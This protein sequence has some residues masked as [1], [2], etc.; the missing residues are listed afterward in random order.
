ML[1][2]QSR[3][4]QK[5][6][7][8][9]G[10]VWIF[11]TAFLIGPFSAQAQVSLPGDALGDKWV[12]GP[13][14]VSLGKIAQLRVP[15][16]SWQFG[17]ATV[18]GNYL[19]KAG[20]PVPKG[21][22]GIMHSAA[23][24]TLVFEFEEAGYVKEPPLGQLNADALLKAFREHFR[25]QFPQAASRGSL[26]WELEPQYNA[27]EHFTEWALQI[28]TPSGAGSETQHNYSVH[29]LGRRGI[30]KVTTIYRGMTDVEGFRRLARGISLRDGERYQDAQP[31]D[32]QSGIQLTDLLARESETEQL[33]DAHDGQSGSQAGTILLWLGLGALVI[34][35][36]IALVLLGKSRGRQTE[37]NARPGTAAAVAATTAAA[38]MRSAAGV[39]TP[40]RS[41]AA[42]TTETGSKAKPQPVGKAVNHHR[43]SRRKK[44]FDYNRYFT[45]LISTVSSHGTLAET[46]GA[47]PYPAEADR[48]VAAVSGLNGASAETSN[49]TPTNEDLIAH[50]TALIEEQRRLIQEQ[51]RLIEEKTKLIAEKNQLLKLQS[52]LIDNKLL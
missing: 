51:T 47:S 33:A 42:N 12:A 40:V 37:A 39:Q 2:C 14:V 8:V 49:G 35:G 38:P 19:R 15:D 44:A 32:K 4:Y 50:Q 7:R 24:W 20:N 9:L 27:D 36:V 22:L 11:S 13:T 30:L 45:D 34:G 31:T 41:V 18:A 16:A 5:L 43:S 48:Y 52:E 23:N 6:V 10:S 17:D 28:N 29:L 1:Y 3:V 46:S 25:R 26:A 21:L